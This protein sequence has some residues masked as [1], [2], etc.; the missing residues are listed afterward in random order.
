MNDPTNLNAPDISSPPPAP[1]PNW[2]GESGVEARRLDFILIAVTAGAVLGLIFLARAE[3]NVQGVILPMHS[4]N[5]RSRWATIYSLAERGT[6]NIDET[7]WPDTIDRVQLNGH[8]YSSK[9]PLLPTLL[10]GEYLLLK[11]LSFG[12]LSFR[13]SPEAV[14]RI[15][16][17]SVNL[18]PLII[19]LVLFSRLLDRL[20]PDPWIRAYTMAAAGLGTFLTG[21]SITLNNHTIAAFS[22]FFA[23][24]PAFLIWCEGQR[25]RRLFALAGFF[26]GFA[27]VNELPALAFLV[28]LGAGLVWKARRQ[29]LTWFLPLALVPIAGH[30]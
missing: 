22:S 25:G 5:D 13:N 4:V 30:F 11:K 8:F 10:A 9:P 12:R 20:A 18:V 6:Y 17:A 16:V 21:Y 3:R 15:V 29:T 23:L 27:A 7:P 24:Y 1:L 28:A 26:A 14:I 2:G 19:F